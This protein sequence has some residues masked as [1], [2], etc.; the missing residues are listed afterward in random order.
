MI[1]MNTGKAP[2]NHAAHNLKNQC[3]AKTNPRSIASQLDRFRKAMVKSST[4]IRG[5]SHKDKVTNNNQ[6]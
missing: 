4:F 3:L 2:I 5:A 6:P 1:I